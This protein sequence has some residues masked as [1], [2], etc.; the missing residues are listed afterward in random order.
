MSNI[1]EQ[2]QPK[3]APKWKQIL[4]NSIPLVITII[5]IVLLVVYQPWKSKFVGNNPYEYIDFD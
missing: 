4:I 2:T 3:N 1:T 5:V